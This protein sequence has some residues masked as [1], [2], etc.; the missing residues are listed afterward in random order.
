MKAAIVSNPLPPASSGQA[1]MLY[2]L[3]KDVDPDQYCL[4][5]TVDIDDQGEN[6][7]QRLGGKYFV[8]ST[9]SELARGYRFGLSFLRELYNVSFGA[10]MRA[11]QIARVVKREQCEAIVSCSSGYDLLDV[12]SGFI[13]SRLTRLPF[14]VYQFDTYSH[15]WA[16]AQA[17]FLGR[18]VESII[19]RRSAGV[20]STNELVRTLLREWY[21]IDSLVIH[22]PCD[23]SAYENLPEHS[24]GRDDLRIVYTGSISEWHFDAFRNLLDAIEIVGRKEL[25]LHVYASTPPEE[26]A[27]K[28]VHGAVVYHP[29][30]SVFAMPKVQHQADILFLPLAFRSRFPEL[31]KVSSPGK[32]GEFLAARTPILV[33]AP[34]ESFL[35]TY[36]RE[37]DC[38]VVVDQNDPKILAEAIDRL[39]TDSELRKRLSQNA[40]KRAV[41]DFSLDIARSRFT[42][43]LKLGTARN[44][45]GATDVA[46]SQ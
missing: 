5:S 32:V 17:S 37:H 13:A 26:L 34:P 30:E 36:F 40:W 46:F 8:I 45:A 39:L 15:M 42:E 11:R 35:S 12:P 6:Y 18:K 19:L 23:I 25:K 29:Y 28:G 4:I 2:R 24:R 41:S 14:Y 21:G 44:S 10:Y 3:L 38:G 1:M 22:N 20:V 9:G 7:S 43:L 16:Q 27:M 33:H 31:M